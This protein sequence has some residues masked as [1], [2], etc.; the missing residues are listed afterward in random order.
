M[1]AHV[2]SFS[3]PRGFRTFDQSLLFSRK[4]FSKVDKLLDRVHKM[5]NNGYL[6][7]DS[8]QYLQYIK[9][10]IRG[11]DIEWRKRNNNMRFLLY[12]AILPNGHFAPCCDHR[13]VNNYPVFDKNF[14]K[15]TKKVF[16]NEVKGNICM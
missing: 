5:R 2:T 1:P 6:L 10:F 16:R 11:K 15:F 12:F 3:S 14:P 13:T 7:Y 4:D 9:K 8:D